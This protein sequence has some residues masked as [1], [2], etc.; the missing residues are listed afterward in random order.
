MKKILLMAA[1]AFSALNMSAQKVRFG[2]NA[3]AGISSLVGSDSKGNGNA[4][5]YK[6]GATIDIPTSE[7]FSFISGVDFIN[8]SFEAADENYNRYFLQLPVMAAYKFSMGETSQFTLKAGPYVG[9][10]V[11]SS[12][13][14]GTDENLFK[15]DYHNRG[16]YGFKVGCSFDFSH[17]TVGAE[18]S[19]AF[20]KIND[21]VK[22]YNQVYGIMLGYKF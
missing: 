20:R 10:G 18:F 14:K 5:A 3:G 4:F 19:R 15:D 21:G 9:I 22:A 1:L 2:I 7:H 16:D 6:V 11:A 13:I 8:K 12:D 17:F